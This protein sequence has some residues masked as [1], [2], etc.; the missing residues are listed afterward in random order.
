[1]SQTSSRSLIGGVLLGI[2][3]ALAAAGVFYLQGY[4]FMRHDHGAAKKK[5]QKTPVLCLPH[6]SQLI[7]VKNPVR[8]PRGRIWCRCMKATPRLRL[9]W[10]QP[11]GERKIKYWISPMDPGYVRDKPGKAPCGMDLVPVYE[12]EPVAA[13]AAPKGERKIKYWVSPMDPGL[14]P[15]QARQGPLRHGSGAGV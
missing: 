10:L 1:M 3:L 7:T 5:E 8:T 9:L 2:I 13:A 11:K 15:G 4:R 12:D 14:C 6:G